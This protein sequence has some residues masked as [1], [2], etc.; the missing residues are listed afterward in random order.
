VNILFISKRVYFIVDN[1]EGG[2]QSR[3]IKSPDGGHPRERSRFQATQKIS[4]V[5]QNPHVIH[6][7]T[8]ANSFTTPLLKTRLRETVHRAFGHGG[9]GSE[10]VVLGYSSTCFSGRIHKG[11]ACCSGGRVVGVLGFLVDPDSRLPKR[12]PEFLK[13][14]T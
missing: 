10:F 14:H 4:R 9:C 5:P 13:I 3:K 2:T 1:V 12:S 7:T 11:K 6:A 8:R